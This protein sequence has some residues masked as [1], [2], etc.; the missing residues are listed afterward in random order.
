MAAN[1]QRCP[2]DVAAGGDDD[3]EVLEEE[4]LGLEGAID[5]GALRGIEEEADEVE[6]IG[7]LALEVEAGLVEP[8]VALA[9]VGE[10]VF[11][12]Q[13]PAQVGEQRGTEGAG[14]GAVGEIDE[15][16]IGERDARAEE[17]DLADMGIALDEGERALGAGLELLVEHAEPAEAVLPVAG[18]LGAGAI[19]AEA[20]EEEGQVLLREAED[21]G[22]QSGILL[23]GEGGAED[24]LVADGVPVIGRLGP[25][26]IFVAIDVVLREIAADA[27]LDGGDEAGRENVRE[28]GE[29]LGHQVGGLGGEEVDVE[30]VA[31]GGGIDV[32]GERP[33]ELGEDGEGLVAQRIEPLA[34]LGGLIEQGGDGGAGEAAAAL[35]VSALEGQRASRL[36][37]T[38]GRVPR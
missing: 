37:R 31:A 1:S 30:R 36:R 9:G 32:G 16:E 35:E 23:E 6:Q 27:G 12:A 11:I 13:A 18:P 2:C 22:E 15:V 21:A 19:A 24:A 20:A 25:E 8:L 3:G 29:E 26:E 33:G 38:R 7:A 14:A 5:G 28:E 4:V 10:E 17:G 34:A